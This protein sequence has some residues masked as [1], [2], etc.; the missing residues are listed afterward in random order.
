MQ[1]PLPS[2]QSPWITKS[3]IVGILF[4][5]SVSVI[6]AASSV[7]IQYI[8]NDTHNTFHSPFLVT[9]IGVSL[10]TLWLPTQHIIK[11]IQQ[12]CRHR[13]HHHPLNTRNEYQTVPLEND[14]LSQHHQDEEAHNSAS[15]EGG[16]DT[17]HLT[18]VNHPAQPQ[19]QTPQPQ[20]QTPA[21][22]VWTEYDHLRTAMCIAPVW[23]IANLTYNTSLIYTT[24]TSSTVLAS[25][26]SLF[27]Y[28]FAIVTQDEQLNTAKLIGVLLGVLGSFITTLSDTTP[29]SKSNITDLGTSSNDDFNF[30]TLKVVS[31]SESTSTSTSIFPL[32]G[33]ILGLISAIGYGAYAVQTRIYCPKDEKLYSMQTMLGYIGLCNFIVLSPVAIYLLLTGRAQVTWMVVGFLVLKGLFDNVL[34]DYLWLRAVILTNATTATVGLGLTIPLA[35]AS[36]VLLGKQSVLS[37]EQIVGALTVL[38][39]FVFVNIGN[40]GNDS[41]ST[42]SSVQQLYPSET[43]G[44]VNRLEY[45]NGNLSPCYSD[46]N[47]SQ[48][49]QEIV[50]LPVPRLHAVS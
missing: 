13:H 40:S 49:G 35:F 50:V 20:P 4:I 15:H 10:F 36:D 31:S 2:Q 43:S 7:L 26:G 18:S 34:S 5:V 9:Y 39:G 27:T 47:V 22:T 38:I 29:N 46:D 3:Y 12:Q 30:D 24:I 33:D 25:T 28:I 37:T 14:H 1:Q 45:T 17:L 41:T 23:F 11:F 6:W 21:I 44:V 19:Q 42:G 48:R 32:I 8:Y 16:A